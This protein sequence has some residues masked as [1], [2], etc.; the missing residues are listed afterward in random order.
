MGRKVRFMVLTLRNIMAIYLGQ[1]LKML[2][3]AVLAEKVPM[4]DQHYQLIEAM[5]Q[6]LEAKPLALSS[7]PF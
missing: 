7:P 2:E 6:E 1:A 4:T 5:R 3:I